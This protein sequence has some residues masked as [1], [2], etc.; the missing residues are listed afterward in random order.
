MGNDHLI[1]LHVMG[2]GELPRGL[3]TGVPPFFN[4]LLEQCVKFKPQERP[5]FRDILQMIMEGERSLNS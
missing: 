3:A 1:R 4:T 5:M 2:G